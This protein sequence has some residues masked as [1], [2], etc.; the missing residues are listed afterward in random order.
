MVLLLRKREGRERGKKGGGESKG[1]K[2]EG[3][4]RERIYLPYTY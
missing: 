4:G 3:K 2:R 1:Q